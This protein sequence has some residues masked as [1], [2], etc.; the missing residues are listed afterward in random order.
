MNLSPSLEINFIYSLLLTLLIEG[1][2]IYLLLTYYFKSKLSKKDIFVAMVLP[3]FT[4]LPYVWFLLPYFLMENY[5]VYLWV[6]ESFVLIIELL[7]LSYLL[8]FT[9]K[10]AFLLAF[11]ANGASYFLGSWLVKMIG[12]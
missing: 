11:I 1:V 9:L 3:S 10:N 4:T 2:V 12:V 7:M 5:T 8:K 6:S